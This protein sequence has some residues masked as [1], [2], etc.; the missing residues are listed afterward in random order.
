MQ[1]VYLHGLK[2]W[3]HFY[4]RIQPKPRMVKGPTLS[5]HLKY[6]ERSLKCICNQ[7]HKFSISL[8][9]RSYIA[10]EEIDLSSWFIARCT[11][12]CCMLY[13]RYE[14]S[15]T[16]IVSFARHQGDL[17]RASKKR[18]FVTYFRRSNLC[19]HVH[20]QSHHRRNV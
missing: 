18:P 10:L 13:T 11:T 17:Y 4:A 7:Y 16:R 1:V 12:H 19:F 8:W 9:K 5:N 3:N 20:I 2:P 14:L 15:F 6:V